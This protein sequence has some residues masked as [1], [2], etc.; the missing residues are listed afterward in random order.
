[1]SAT[2]RTRVGTAAAALAIAT[3]S[4]S[5]VAFQQTVF[6]SRSDIVVIDVAVTDGRS[7]VTT[8]TR[9]D[10]DLRDNGVGQT[11][12]DFDR[13]T[14]PLDVTLTIDISG[15]MTK[16]KRA[17]VE[18]AIAQVSAALLPAD[19][20]AVLTFGAGVTEA[21]PLRHAPIAADLSLIGRG[22]S[23]FDALLLSLVAAPS[24][25]RRQLTVFMTDGDDTTSLFDQRT[26]LDTAEHTVAQV[27]F[28]LL[29][30]GGADA[31]R[32]V[33]A[34]FDRI[35]RA[36]GGRVLEIDADEQLSGA[37]LQ[38]ITDFRQSYILR[39]APAG[40]PESG[41]HDVTVTTSSGKYQVRA[42]RGYW[43]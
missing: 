43:R 18:R 19:R 13:G 7:P 5:V 1:M 20:G 41:W 14:L 40:V 29:R 24:L 16:A 38:T 35:A 31:D 32:A 15:S 37:F 2:G 23:V 33:R 26:V 30:G 25:H 39:Y 3:A 12:L 34:A 10:F 4:A 28:V 22:T 17:A 42:R 9:D 11:I 21:A 6:R 27:S 8:L 36:T